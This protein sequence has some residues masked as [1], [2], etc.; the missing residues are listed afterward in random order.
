[1]NEINARMRSDD[2]QITWINK[3]TQTSWHFRRTPSIFCGEVNQNVNSYGCVHTLRCQ[4]QNQS[5]APFPRWIPARNF[6]VNLKYFFENSINSRAH[7]NSHSPAHCHWTQKIFGATDRPIPLYAVHS[8][9]R[10]K[11]SVLSHLTFGAASVIASRKCVS[12][13]YFCKW[14]EE[15]NINSKW[16]ALNRRKKFTRSTNAKIIN[17]NE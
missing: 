4:R 12:L 15:E 9:C 6:L 5:N 16:R 10:W 11:V 3:N 2:T 7:I 17:H 13:F 1:M 14:M 8:V